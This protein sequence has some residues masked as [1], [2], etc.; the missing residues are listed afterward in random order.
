MNFPIAFFF[1]YKMALEKEQ[2][3]ISFFNKNQKWSYLFFFY[4]KAA[5]L[6]IAF[7][8]LGQL[9]S[10]R[11]TSMHIITLYFMFLNVI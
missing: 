4:T 7:T 6:M 8:I 11:N 10:S 5:N 9:N 2:H 1:P 3:C